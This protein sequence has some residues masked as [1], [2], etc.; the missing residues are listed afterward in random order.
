MHCF[1]AVLQLTA[2]NRPAEGDVQCGQGLLAVAG[3][4]G[5]C[6]IC[7]RGGAMKSQGLEAAIA[8]D[9]GQPRISE[10]GRVACTQHL[11]IASKNAGE[12]CWLLQWLLLQQ[13]LVNLA[14]WRWLSSKAYR[15]I[16]YRILSWIGLVTHGS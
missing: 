12:C 13:L 6:G 10:L 4:G 14:E 11:H 15:R 5:Q 16:L 2:R 1:T 3:K 8:D 7:D 9:R